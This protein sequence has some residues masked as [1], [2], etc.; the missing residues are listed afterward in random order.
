MPGFVFSSTLALPAA[1]ASS[2]LL[3]PSAVNAELGPWLRMTMP[4]PWGEQ[5]LPAWPVGRP[6]FRSVILLLGVLPLDLHHFRL[7]ATGEAGFYERSSSLL[8]RSWRHKRLLRAVPG[9]TFV[10][11]R[12]VFACRLPVLGSLLA[13][14]YRAVFR[15][16]HRRLR[17]WYAQVGEQAP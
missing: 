6:L 15:H 4:A 7:E 10:E 1:D 16:R 12:L 13:P 9:G 2:R 14:V 5:P 11:D 3:R 17:R 8:L